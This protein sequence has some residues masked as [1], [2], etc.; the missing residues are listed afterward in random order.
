M[1]LGLVWLAAAHA[2]TTTGGVNASM[3]DGSVRFVA[4]TIAN[5]PWR[6]LHTR[7]GGEVVFQRGMIPVH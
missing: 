4:E 7:D 5:I 3:A 2:A 1:V 6:H